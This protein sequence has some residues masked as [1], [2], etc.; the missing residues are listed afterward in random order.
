MTNC[1]GKNGPGELLSVSLKHDYYQELPLPDLC[2]T[3]TN[4]RNH[5]IWMVVILI[6]SCHDRKTLDPVA[7]R[8]FAFRFV[9]PGEFPISYWHKNVYRKTLKFN[10][11]S[12]VVILVRE[13]PS[14]D[15]HVSRSETSKSKNRLFTFSTS[16]FI[17]KLSN[18]WQKKKNTGFHPINKM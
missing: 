7:K 16:V 18:S 15:D 8:I 17:L 14:E 2:L 1:P 13:M 9:V 3:G 6:F 10:I 12:S 5:T 11:F 4:S